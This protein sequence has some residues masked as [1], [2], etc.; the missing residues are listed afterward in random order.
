MCFKTQRDSNLPLPS[1]ERFLGQLGFG[2]NVLKKSQTKLENY[3]KCSPKSVDNLKYVLKFQYG[4]R[5]SVL[6]L[7]YLLY[8]CINKAIAGKLFTTRNTKFVQVGK[9]ML[10]KLV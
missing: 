8:E 6:I 5:H 4:K 3:K 7:C 9:A 2:K 1:G 10:G